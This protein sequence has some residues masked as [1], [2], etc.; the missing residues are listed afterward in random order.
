M[1][2]RPILFSAPMIRA[3]LR[4][5]EVP[6]T[7]K[8]QTRRILKLHN[9]PPQYIGPKGCEKDPTCWGWEGPDGGYALA[10]RDSEDPHACSWHD[11]EASYRPCDRLWVREAHA[12]VPASAY[13]CSDGV[14]QT[15]NPHDR[16]MAAVYRCGWER[17]APRWRPSIHMPHWASRITL[18]V[19]DVRVQRLHDIS[20]DDAAAEGFSG[21]LAGATARHGFRHL[22]DSLN[23]KRGYGWERNPWIV[24]LTFRPRLGNIDSGKEQP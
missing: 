2:D 15:I 4:E 11:L 3:I 5:I 13:R 18:D 8:T 10:D 6:G 20:E 17:S 9:E 24:A 14:Q 22:W 23:G 21:T 16:D 1:T 19:T 7:G 12:L